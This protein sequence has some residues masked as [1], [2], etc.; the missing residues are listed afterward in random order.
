MAGCPLGLVLGRAVRVCCEMQSPGCGTLLAARNEPMRLTVYKLGRLL[1]CAGK[2][3]E[4]GG[5]GSR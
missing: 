1:E 2:Q 4:R 5:Q 3:V